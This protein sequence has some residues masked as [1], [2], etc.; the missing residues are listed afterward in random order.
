MLKTSLINNPGFIINPNQE[1]IYKFLDINYKNQLDITRIEQLMPTFIASVHSE[2][3]K[4]YVR[5][6]FTHL[7]HNFA[8]IYMQ[9]PYGYLTKVKIFVYHSIENLDDYV[10]DAIITKSKV[11]E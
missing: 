8:N 9:R 11:A 10:V 4:N 6:G 7:G 1:A 5:R 3:V 2:L